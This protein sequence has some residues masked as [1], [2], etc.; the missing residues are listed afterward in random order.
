MGIKVSQMVKMKINCGYFNKL[1]FNDK[2]TILFPFRIAIYGVSI[3]YFLYLF[4]DLVII[5]FFLFAKKL[6]AL[7][8]K[9]LLGLSLINY[10]SNRVDE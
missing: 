2:I 4:I 6:V 8:C 1:Y 10:N 7:L 5:H 3:Y 9:R